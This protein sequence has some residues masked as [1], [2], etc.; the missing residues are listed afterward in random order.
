[1][2]NIPT[3]AEIESAL[4]TEL[5]IILDRSAAEIT[6]ET[7]LDSLGLDSIRLMEVMIFIEKTYGVNLADAGLSRE[8]LRSLSALAARVRQ[9]RAKD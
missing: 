9:A 2:S 3:S 7:T 1:M 4:Q 6:G 8:D 5:A